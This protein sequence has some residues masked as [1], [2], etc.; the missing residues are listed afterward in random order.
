MVKQADRSAATVSA[1]LASAQNL[2]RV[3]GYDAVTIDHIA[4]AAGCRK[5]AVYHHFASKQVIF[6][7]VLDELQGTLA[8]ELAQSVERAFDARSAPMMARCIQ[9]YL[10]GANR[11]EVRQI[12]L[13]DGPVVLGWK[14]F[15]EIDDRH[16]AGMVRAG[17]SILM[18][19]AAPETLVDTATRLTLGA[20]MEAAIVC[21]AAA[22]PIE[23]TSNYSQPFELMLSGF[24]L[25]RSM[26]VAQKHRRDHASPAR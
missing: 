24:A 9:A 14:R 16:F 4:D 10:E 7:T 18:D 20:I 8:S 11:P 22:D 5:G 1:I 13:I 12:L 2:F 19:G 25:T 21:S 26:H 3:N 6:E 23:A 17:V 15:R